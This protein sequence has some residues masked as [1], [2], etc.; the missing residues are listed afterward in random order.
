MITLIVTLIFAAIGGTIGEFCFSQH[1]II[2]SIVGAIV[3]LLI[4][5]ASTEGVSGISDGF[6]FGD[7]GGD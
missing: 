3:G 7:F 2:G 1:C 5:F 6:D 4:R